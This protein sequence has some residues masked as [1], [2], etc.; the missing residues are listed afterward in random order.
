MNRPELVR[1]LWRPWLR[2]VSLILPGLMVEAMR[3]ALSKFSYEPRGWP[4]GR[5]QENAALSRDDERQWPVLVHNLQ[6][7]GPL[8]VAHLAG[9]GTRENRQDHNTMMS[10]GYVLARASRNKQSLS[11]L[12]W[13]ARTGHYYLYTQALLPEI[14]LDYHCYETPAICEAGRRRLPNVQFHHGADH[15][16][17]AH[18]DLVISSSSLHYFEN[19]REIAKVLA[20]RTRGFLYVARLMVVNRVPSFVV[21]Q[22][23]RGP[24]GSSDIMSWFINRQELLD[25]FDSLGMDLIREFVFSEDWRPKKAPER[26]DCRGFLFRPRQPS[27]T[28]VC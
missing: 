5:S 18:F 12:D 14:M 2:G 11:V 21:K 19:W 6:G 28:H 7:T 15:L 17:G 8:G 4:T 1:S 9:H 10:Y 24:E 16:A 26:G 22:R 23:Y 13:G 20:A 25:H 27:A 3:D